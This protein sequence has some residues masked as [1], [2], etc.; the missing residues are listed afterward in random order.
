M[1]VDKCDRLWVLD[2]GAVNLAQRVD[3]IC[4]V[5][6]DI[7]DLKTDKHIR[8]YIIPTNQTSRDSLLTN[9]VIDVINNN[10]EDAY[11]Y[12]SD[13][14]QYGLIVYSYKEVMTLMHGL[15]KM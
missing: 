3:Q 12:M 8:R 9:I 6:L 11:A 4:P 7:F 14:F 2:T 15:C 10:C 13:V 5:K 1:E